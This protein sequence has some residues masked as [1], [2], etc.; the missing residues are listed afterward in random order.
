M[1]E[2]SRTYGREAPMQ[3]GRIIALDTH[4]S[5]TVAAILNPAGKLLS[6]REVPTEIPALRALIESVPRPR[7]VVLE[8]GTLADWLVRELRPCAEEVVACD[9]RRN[10]HIAKD[11]DKDDPIDAFKLGQ[12]YR[13]DFVKVVHHP[14][15][16]ERSAFKQLVGLYGDEVRSWVRCANRILAQL[17]RHGIFSSK[18]E[19]SMRQRDALL[20]RVP[21]KSLRAALQVK[22]ADFDVARAGVV[23]LGR[24]V[25][26]GARQY[27]PIRRFV[28]LPGVKWLRGATFYVYVDTPWRFARKQALW[29]YM[30]IGLERRHSGT[31]PTRVGVPAGV[32]VCRP[33]KAMIL[34]AAK[35]AISGDNP[36]AERYKEWQHVGVTPRNAVRNVARSLAA[37]LWALFKSGGVYEPAWVG[38]DRTSLRSE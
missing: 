9:P 1:D 30:G 29:R 8:E 14:A 23:S 19:L 24:M 13:G 3:T 6:Q 25:T 16:L 34:G 33:L 32:T 5:F 21:V 4:C 27:E 38:V 22:L 31:G 35:S 15:T 28:A 18:D 10:A 2:G 17:A 11:G 36:F 26:R 7:R 20:R 37:T 12:L